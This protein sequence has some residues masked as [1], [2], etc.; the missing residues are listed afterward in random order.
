MVVAGGGV[1]FRSPCT[2]NLD[3]IVAYIFEN[4]KEGPYTLGIGS[5]T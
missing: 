4:Y 5:Y 1:A 2:G 3:V